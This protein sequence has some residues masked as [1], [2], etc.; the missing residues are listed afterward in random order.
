MF[1]TLFRKASFARHNKRLKNQRLLTSMVRTSFMR[2][3]L[4]LR[5]CPIPVFVFNYSELST[6]QLR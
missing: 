2:P 4:Q 1:T 5:K 3:H 6:P